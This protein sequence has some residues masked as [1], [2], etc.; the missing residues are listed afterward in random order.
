[1]EPQLIPASGLYIWTLKNN[2]T[3]AAQPADQ[4]FKTPGFNID[5]VSVRGAF[6]NTAGAILPTQQTRDR[7][8]LQI[9]A[10]DT[11][12]V[13][14]STPCDVFAFLSMWYDSNSNVPKFSLAANTNYQV[15]FTVDSATALFGATYPIRCELQ[16]IGAKR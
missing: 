4:V 2:I 8:M 5:V 1:M 6:F 12:A 13:L 9:L 14:A 16:F 3:A 7:I 10:N 11:S 15:V